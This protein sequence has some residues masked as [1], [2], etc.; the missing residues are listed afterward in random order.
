[1]KQLIQLLQVKKIIALLLT[2]VFCYLA[3]I[4]K[5]SSEQFLT[6]FSLV[7]AF[8]FGQSTARQTIQENKVIDT[9]TNTN[10]NE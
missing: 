4:G 2:V 1:M 3:V 9:N 7:V 6:V 8:Y 10:A 5:V